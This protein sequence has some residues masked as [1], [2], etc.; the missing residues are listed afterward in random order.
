MMVTL[1]V[2]LL[3]QGSLM[4]LQG[5]LGV[6]I[7]APGLR[8]ALVEDSREGLTTVR[9]AGTL[10]SANVAG[11]FTM[12]MS[13]ITIG[14]FLTRGHLV[15][16]RLA[17]AGLGVGVVAMILTYSRGS[18]IGF[19]IGLVIILAVA[20]VRGVAQRE[21]TL[22]LLGG[23]IVA[24]LFANPIINRFMGDDRGSAAS[25][26][27]QAKAA[28]N[29][30]QAHMFT[31]I[32]ASNQIFVLRDYLPVELMGDRNI[33]LIHNKFWSI[34]AETGLFGFLALIWFLLALAGQA[35]RTV[36]TSVDPYVVIFIASLLAAGIAYTFR[37]TNDPF[38]GRPEVQLLWFLAALIAVTARLAKETGQ[39]GDPLNN[40]EVNP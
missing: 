21:V 12:F 19:G 39:I 16:Q 28:F 10:A 37:L 40:I 20:T 18:W 33:Y 8:T 5:T 7:S 15:D 29:I 14:L 13:L 17:L 25:R 32:G 2:C 3:L 6:E 38:D 23:I 9:V 22:I 36:I 34:W 30:I 4:V 24:S 31:G 1:V 35:I 26:I 27:Y 11:T